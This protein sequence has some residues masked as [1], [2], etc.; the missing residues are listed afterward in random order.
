MAA[1]VCAVALV[2]GPFV[3]ILPRGVAIS[4]A[5]WWCRAN[6]KLL[7]ALVGIDL[8]I[9]GV[10]NIPKG[11]ALVAAKHHSALETF[12]LMPSLSDPAFVLKRELT[13]LPFF[14]WFLLRMKMIA[15]DRKAGSEALVQIIEQAKVAAADGRQI[16]IY[17]EGTRRKVGEAPRYKLGVGHLYERLGLPCHPVAIDAGVFWPKGTIARRQG[18]AVIEFLDPIPAGLDRVAFQEMVRQRIETAT[19]ALVAEAR[20][21]KRN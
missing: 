15:I 14:G 11:A 3:L 8:E 16:V 7:R 9:R 21:G 4:V 13:W 17:P 18:R 1:L 20:Y 5:D 10:E 19:E 6:L 2:T 12:G